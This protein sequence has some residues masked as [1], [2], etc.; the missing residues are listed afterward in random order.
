MSDAIVLTLRASGGT[1]MDAS[2]ITPD[3]CATLSESEIAALPIW[4]GG[5]ATALA[6]VFDVRGGNANRLE[7]D[8]DLRHVDGLGAETAG[9]T[10]I[11]RGD[12]GHGVG[13]RMTGGLV[14]VHGNAGDDAGQ[15][16]AGGIL[17]VDGQ[18]GDRLGA[19]APGA[20]KGMTGG[21][22]VVLGSAGESAGALMRRGLVAVAG[23]VGAFAGRGMIA[24]TLL[25]LGPVGNQ[26]GLGSK[27]GSIIAG[28]G[29]R[30]PVTYRFACTYEPPHVRLLL[31][32]LRRRFAFPADTALLAGAYDRYCGDAGD[33]GKGE[34]LVWTG[35]GQAAR[36]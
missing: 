23:G 26:P 36:A 30:V 22:I 29:V 25:A 10:L 2:G 8:G 7:V 20:A 11:L 1:T 17:R 31:T 34:I 15:G 4:V 6:E 12:A 19:A 5:R 27:R 18:A 16:M 13:A 14:H 9:G 21:E 24:G 35:H 28:A 32:S 33:P 3:R